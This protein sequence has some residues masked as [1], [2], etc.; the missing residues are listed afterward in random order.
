M[1]KL[2]NYLIFILLI[3]LFISVS[4]AK[5]GK[6]KVSER[7]DFVTI[8]NQITELSFNL[9]DGTYVVTDKKSGKKII[10]D[11]KLKINNWSSD[12]EGLRRT[13]EKRSISDTLGTGIALDLSLD[14][15]SV[16]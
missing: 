10:S 7:N 1:K 11:A 9:A 4:C 5:S 12:D 3:T 15:K 2:S 13:W 14:R 16:V 6:V 8:E